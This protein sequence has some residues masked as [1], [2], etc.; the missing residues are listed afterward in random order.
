[1][2]NS[3]LLIQQIPSCVFWKDI[4]SVFQGCNK[5]FA[6]IAGLSSPE[7]V[8]GKTD[9]D[10]PWAESFAEQYL[11]SDRMVLEGV[12]QDSFLETQVQASG[13]T[14]INIVNKVPLFDENNNKIG[15]IGCFS[16]YVA[17]TSS[18]ILIDKLENQYLTRREVDCAK[19]LIHG[20]SAKK[21][22]A[23]LNLSQ[24]T[25]QHYIENIR[26]KLGAANKSELIIKL[27]HLNINQ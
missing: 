19:L 11:E 5:Y 6:H 3:N 10:M 20:L 22:A 23:E 9:F 27:C 12:I 25:V 7:E 14:L 13:R 8:I 16:E 17:S 1:M 4:H 2:L 18:G 24:R 15:V 26:A 21:I